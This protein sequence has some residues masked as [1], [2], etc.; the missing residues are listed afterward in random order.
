MEWLD[1]LVCVCY[2]FRILPN[3]FPKL[4]YHFTLPV[5][6]CESFGGFTSLITYGTVSVSIWDILM[7]TEW[8]FMAVFKLRVFYDQM[9]NIFRCVSLPSVVLWWNDSN[10]SN[11]I[12]CI[13]ICFCFLT[14]FECAFLNSGYRPFLRYVTCKYLLPVYGLSLLL[15]VFRRLERINFS[16]FKF[17]GHAFGVVFKKS[18]GHL[19]GS[20]S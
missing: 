15:S 10:N 18:L 16:F 14:E 19:G 6:M 4:L 13:L 20:V 3:Y 1:R 17:I 9:L 11:Q 8:D 7:G 2:L 12:Y 5:A